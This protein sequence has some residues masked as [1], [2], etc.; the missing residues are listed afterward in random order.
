MAILHQSG[1]E[2]RIEGGSQNKS[3]RGINRGVA[4]LIK[5]KAAVSLLSC[6][7]LSQWSSKVEAHTAKLEVAA[8][9]EDIS[10]GLWHW[11]LVCASPG[12]LS[13]P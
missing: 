11:E 7:R 2:W 6:V 1:R 8:S 13:P 10:L 12:V 3:G 5:H 4:Q 9:W